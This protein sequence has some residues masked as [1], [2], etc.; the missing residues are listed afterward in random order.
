VLLCWFVDAIVNSFSVFVHGRE[1]TAMTVAKDSVT[2]LFALKMAV[3]RQYSACKADTYA[4]AR[5][6]KIEYVAT[7]PPPEGARDI[8]NKIGFAACA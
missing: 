7:E 1:S 4:G 5:G 2:T 8:K 3:T 6:H